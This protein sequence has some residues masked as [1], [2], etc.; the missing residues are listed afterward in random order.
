MRIC[1]TLPFDDSESTSASFALPYGIAVI[2][3]I[4]KEKHPSSEVFFSN[5]ESEILSADV[6]CCS[7]LSESWDLVNQ[8]GEKAVNLNKRFIVGG[9]HVTAL[10]QTLRFGECF[11]G[12]MEKIDKSW[13]NPLP[14]WSIFSKDYLKHSSFTVMTSRGCHYKCKFCSSSAFWGTYIPLPV[15]RVIA[16]IKQLAELGAKKIIMFDD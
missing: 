4:I 6:I 13:P 9:Q 12:P 8:L 11:N 7:G 16:E 10:P 5:N 3:S 2:A 14:D 15:E 1:L